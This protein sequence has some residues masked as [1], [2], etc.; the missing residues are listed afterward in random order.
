MGGPQICP[1]CDCGIDPKIRQLST[2]TQKAFLDGY[3]AGLAAGRLEPCDH[4]LEKHDQPPFYQNDD[5]SFSP[6]I[7]EDTSLSLQEALDSCW[8]FIKAFDPN[9][10]QDDHPQEI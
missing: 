6:A 3:S 4:H 8:A 5:G 1:A 10:P 7:R 2:L 9:Y